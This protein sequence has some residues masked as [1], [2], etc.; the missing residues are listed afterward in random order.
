MLVLLHFPCWNIINKVPSLLY[1]CKVQ[2]VIT[3]GTYLIGAPNI[4]SISCFVS[5]TFIILVWFTDL[6][7]GVNNGNVSPTQSSS[8]SLHSLPRV[9]VTDVH[10][11]GQLAGTVP[12]FPSM[13]AGNDGQH[14]HHTSLTPS[15]YC[16]FKKNVP[17]YSSF[18]IMKQK[19]YMAFRENN[20]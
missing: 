19:V 20:S 2:F 7:H 1:S 18:R 12:E 9:T 3:A 14:S 11:H 16:Q 6:L 17:E 15:P 8:S 4:W 10:N 5:F 13:G